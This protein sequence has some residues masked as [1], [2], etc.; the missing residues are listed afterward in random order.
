MNERI[1]AR[2]A[3]VVGSDGEQ[4]GIMS[5]REALELARE[6]ELDLIEVSPNSTPPVC[7][8]MDYGRYKYEQ[9]KREKDQAK[10]QRGLEMKTVRIRPSTDDHDLQTKANTARKF[11]EEGRKVKFN[12]LFRGREQAYQD[13]AARKLLRMAE[14]LSDVSEL[15]RSPSMD[16]RM[17]IMIL[18]P[19]G[20]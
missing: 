2:E 16:G 7:K 1:R 15:E 13:L 4:L 12:M 19:K 6:Q 17:M 3:R 18:T 10:T 8:I 11:L 20:R 14:G 9:S 5:V